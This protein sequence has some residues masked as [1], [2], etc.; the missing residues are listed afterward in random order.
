[1]C[2]VLPSVMRGATFSILIAALATMLTGCVRSTDTLD[3][4]SFPLRLKFAYTYNRE[5]RDL[6]AEEIDCVSLRLYDAQTGR[7]VKG[8]DISASEIAQDGSY[9]WSA[10]VGTYTLVAWGGVKN[11][12]RLVHHDQLSGHYLHLPCDGN[13]A[14]D[15][16]DEHLWHKMLTD[17]LINGDLTPC[18]TVDLHKLSN[19]VTVTV[20]GERSVESGEGLRSSALITVCNGAYRF[21]GQK[22]PEAATITYRPLSQSSLSTL[23][24]PL[25]TLSTL[26]SHRFTTLS[27]ERYDGSHLEVSYDGTPIYS[28]GLS[29]LIAQQPDIIFDLDDDFHINFDVAGQG[30]SLS[31]TISVNDWVVHSYNVSLQ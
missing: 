10:P 31:V 23:R 24:S 16:S 5:N 14:V 26:E 30:A 11:R 3:E 1:M 27:L 9:T 4:C 25:S 7:F 19:D 22:H 15:Q 17:I 28:G 29:E 6:F 8:T 13:G 2:V 21:D 18:Y 12:Y 20:S